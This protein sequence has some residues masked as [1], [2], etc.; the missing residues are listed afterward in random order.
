MS[1]G[2]WY[3]KAIYLL[4]A[5]ALAL[6][7]GIPFVPRA[8]AS[9][10]QATFYSTDSDGSLIASSEWPYSAA[11]NASSG[12]VSSNLTQIPVGQSGA[13]FF[14][15]SRGAVSFNTSSLPDDACITSATLSLYGAGNWSNTDFLI[16]VVD[17]SGLHEPLEGSDYG[18]LRNQTVSGGTFN[19]S[20]FNTSGYNDIPLNETG[21]GWISKTGITKFGLRSSRDITSTEPSDFELVHIYASEQD[22]GCQPRLVVTYTTP[23]VAAFNATPTFCCAPLT[24]NFT[25]LSTANITGWNW[26]FPG[27]SPSTAT[28][29]GPHSVN[30]MSPG[31]YGVILAVANDCGED[32]ETKTDYITVGGPPTVNFTANVTGGCAPLMVQFIDNS[33]AN[34][35]PIT[36]W[37]WTFGDGG[38]STDQNPSHNYTSPGRYTVILTVT[39]DCGPNR[40]R[41]V[42][43]ITISQPPAP[44]GGE[45][46]AVSKISLLAPWIAVALLLAGGISWYVLRRR[47]RS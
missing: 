9:P 36:S 14:W 16:T 22:A 17:G 4:I 29:Q 13:I 32:S 27:G 23:P 5:L 6:F 44:I 10:G 20:G 47:A 21:M 12:A 43:Y 18:Y 30:Y 38:T 45:A 8:A 7:T 19:T 42:D 40:Q 39:S 11:H 41:K 24:V 1:K 2:K 15:V 46:Y 31:T 26:T 37:S 33:T 35:K 3:Q 28:G 25:D 34:N